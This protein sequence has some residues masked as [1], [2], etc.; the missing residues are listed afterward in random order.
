MSALKNLLVAL[1]VLC[2]ASPAPAA[3]P[4]GRVPRVTRAEFEKLVQEVAQQRKLLEKI[5]QLQQE[6]V[7]ALTQLLNMQAVQ[8][9][10]VAVAPDPV[11]P[12]PDPVR[13]PPTRP[14]ADP[15]P[16]RPPSDPVVV[17]P[18][19]TKPAMGSVVG[20]VV[21]RGG[22]PESA[23]VYVETGS[24]GV[25][26]TVQMTQKN[27]QFA[28][29]VLVVQRGTRVEF[30]NMD[31]IFH[32]VFSLSQ[33]NAFDL[34]TYKQGESKG[35]VM[36]Q[37]GVVSVYCNI[38]PQMIGFILVVPGRSYARVGKEGFFHLENLPPGKH[39]LAAWAPNARQVTRDVTVGDEVVNV[40]LT[41]TVGAQKP[42]TRK[43]GSPYGSYN[44]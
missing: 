41:L 40:E 35:V 23:W 24:G 20:K 18:P 30:P 9:P 5:V 44:E 27:K 16:V 13:P 4:K 8:M 15:P 3:P 7:K 25:G 29:N 38:H 21:V 26:K 31:P 39:R 2:A 43:D 33:G 32:N 37:P 14:P 36:T 6:H 22:S 17:P 1:C 11:R 12:P 34:G 10:P 19:P 28:P 42:H